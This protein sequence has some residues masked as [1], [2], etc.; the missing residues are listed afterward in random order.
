MDDGSPLVEDKT[1]RGMIGSL[2]YLT[3][4]RPDIIFSVG[5]CPHFQSKPN[6][7]HLK[8]VKRIL[9]Y[10]SIQPIQLFGTL[11]NATLI[12]L[13]M[14]MLIMQVSWLIGKAHQVQLTFQDLVWQLGQPRNNTQLPCP[15]LKQNMQLQPL[16]VLNY[17]G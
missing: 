3:A 6:G 8:V 4:S 7:I 11:K 10:L 1:Y 2:L 15:Q 17:C 12:L 9:T 16:A 13:D 5:L 14:L